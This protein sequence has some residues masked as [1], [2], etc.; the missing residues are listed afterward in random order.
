MD[1]VRQ[2]NSQWADRQAGGD[3]VLAREGVR[4]CRHVGG[5]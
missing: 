2:L 1:I 3:G 5:G 4:G